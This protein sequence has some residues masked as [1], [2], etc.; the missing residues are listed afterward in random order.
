LVLLVLVFVFGVVCGSGVTLLAIARR[1]RQEIAQPELRV[2]RTAARLARR[3]DL[4]AEQQDQL[5]E[6]LERQ[7]ADFAS[8]RRQVAPEV[9]ARLRQ[10]DREMQAILT[11]QQQTEWR[12]ILRQLRRDWLPPEVRWEDAADE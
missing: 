11:P 12:N 3:L 5:S 8:L 1:A 9:V 10:T 7:Q 6:I 4:T 2:A